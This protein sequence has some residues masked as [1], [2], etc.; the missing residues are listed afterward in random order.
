MSKVTSR[1][2][3]LA[4][5]VLQELVWLSKDRTAEERERRTARRGAEERERLEQALKPFNLL[6]LVLRLRADRAFSYARQILFF[7]RRSQ[8]IEPELRRVHEEH[9][10]EAGGDKPPDDPQ[11][12][13][14]WK[15]ALKIAGDPEMRLRLAQHHT[16]CTYKDSSLPA[17]TRLDE[18]LKILR[19]ADDLAQTVDQE[20]L[21][22]AGAIHK[23]LWET[24]GLRRH[25]ERSLHYYRRGYEVGVEKDYGYTGVNAAYVLD[26][27]AEQELKLARE[28]GL[29]ASEVE[30]RHMSAELLRDAADRIRADIVIALELLPSGAGNEWLKGEW[31]FLVTMAEACFGLGFKDDQYFKDADRYLEAAA[32]LTGVADWEFESSARQLATLA[33]LRSDGDLSPDEFWESEAFSHL[34]PLFKEKAA[35]LR[36]SLA[37]KV[38]LVFS[39]GG[40][41]AALFHVGMLAKLAEL[42]M[43][44]NVEV[45]SCV[46]AGSIIAALYYIELR[47]LLQGRPDAKIKRD[48]YVELVMRVERDFLGAVQRNIRTRLGAEFWTNFKTTVFPNYTRTDRVG[49]MLDELLY[50]PAAGVERGARLML[51]ELDILPHGEDAAT[52]NPSESNWRRA[53]K[54]PALVINATT[55]NTGHNWQFTTDWMGEPATSIDPETDR[56]PRLRPVRYAHAPEGYKEFPLGRAVAASTCTLGLMEPV[57]LKGLYPGMNVQLVDGVF[58]GVLSTSAAL[59]RDCNVL[60]VSDA[61]GQM[62]SLSDPGQ[63][64]LSTTLLSNAV[65]FGHF[66]AREHATLES[67]RRS[68]LLRGLMYLHM[69]KGLDAEA[70]FAEEDSPAA[71][72][73]ARP[74]TPTELTPYG[75]LK[76]VQRRLADI[77][78]DLDSFSDAE[79][80]ALMM[81][82][83][84]MTA[85]EF[86]TC[87]AGYPVPPPTRPPWRFL[88]IE[89]PMKTVGN[90][91]LTGLLDAASR[92]LFK[93]S[94]SFPVLRS[95]LASVVTTLLGL[96]PVLLFASAYLS[97]KARLLSPDDWLSG[98]SYF[99]VALAALLLLLL[100]YLVVLVRTGRKATSQIIVGV[101]MC[102]AG[103]IFSRL[104]LH[105]L[106][107][108]Y[109]SWGRIGSLDTG[110]GAKGDG[111][112]DAA[113]A[114]ARRGTGASAAIETLR[115]KV[116][117]TGSVKSIGRMVDHARAVE[118]VAR[119]FE[120]RG[121]GT[122]RYPRDQKT[123]PLQLKIDLHARR[124]KH[125]I[126][127]VVR[128]R[129][130]ITDLAGLGAM[131][132]LEAAVY[133]QI[134]KEKE[135]EVSEAE[136]LLV[137]ID[138]TPD[139]KLE[140]LI[141]NAQ[142]RGVWIVAA[143]YTEAEV[144]SFFDAVPGDTVLEEGTRRLEM[145]IPSGEPVPAAAAGGVR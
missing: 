137:F 74:Q 109:L 112:T 139:K 125:Q 6:R 28:S 105:L 13:A 135:Q 110:A 50:N 9:S 106:D 58:S 55:L 32:A 80:Y 44:R 78:T 85:H 97:D 56:Q 86:A 121:Y 30:S 126:L 130:E 43:L 131:S 5:E 118:A 91:Q 98:V 27:L 115:Q 107:P 88:A 51:N 7:M 33:R 18:A 116:D 14:A 143:T 63:G 76:E 67:R 15:K 25:L 48:D 114:D 95:V 69:R 60:L 45:I 119:L 34:L 21:G 90:K 8:V 104:T 23:R 140:G 29:S 1:I 142:D 37:G 70:L 22:L 128:T 77:R 141:E 103:F 49:E 113:A 83:Y 101:F 111:T 65:M 12:R 132:E 124:G 53:A 122:T 75:V 59:E 108:L 66:R 68:T 52:F 81:S 26:L 96:L 73:D 84:L 57:T 40:F 136:G 100:V 145:L 138:T 20:S 17:W 92:Q 99:T 117:V 41:R 133:M 94:E 47:E 62:R 87:V 129:N 4:E 93:F 71:P 89:E 42:D 35:G 31:W 123:N 72:D 24:E 144:E 39:G 10:R 82:G 19:E 54:V 11:E 102:T 36:A 79:A 120:H 3:T 46:S 127:T 38:G 134:K 16:L 2:I 64:V 61:T